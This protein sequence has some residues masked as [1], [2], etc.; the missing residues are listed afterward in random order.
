[1][2][3]GTTDRRSLAGVGLLISS[4]PAAHVLTPSQPVALA[5]ELN[6]F[7]AQAWHESTADVVK[8]P[9]W[10]ARHSPTVPSGAVVPGEQLRQWPSPVDVVPIAHGPHCGR[11]EAR[12]GKMGRGGKEEMDRWGR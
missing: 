3:A 5:T 6:V 1:M 10:Q 4:S 7:C 9:G 12:E 2:L 8:V 11:G